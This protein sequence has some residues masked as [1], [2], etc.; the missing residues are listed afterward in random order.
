M[1]DQ[2]GARLG[3]IHPIGEQQLQGLGGLLAAEVAAAAFAAA[4]GG[5]QL[6]QP[7][8]SGRQPLAAELPSLI[9]RGLRV[10]AGVRWFAS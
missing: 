3:G 2:E 4:D 1:G 10:E 8:F 6:P 7:A 9:D 5:E